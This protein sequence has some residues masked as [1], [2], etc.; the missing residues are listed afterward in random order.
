MAS[1]ISSSTMRQPTSTSTT[2]SHPTKDNNTAGNV[3]KRY[4]HSFPFFFSFSPFLSSPG[5]DNSYDIR[6]QSE[7]LTLMTSPP[8]SCTAFPHNGNLH[9]WRATILGPSDTPYQALTFKLSF[10]FPDRYPFVPPEV[11]F[12]TPIYHPNVDMKGRICLDILKDKWSAVLNVGSVLISLQSLLGEPNKYVHT[13]P[14]FFRLFRYVLG[15]TNDGG[16]QCKS[17]EWS[18][19]GIMGYGHGRI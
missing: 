7:L 6:L 12:L 17:V 19:C 9:H 1:S 3:T 4:I 13:K 14:P 15:G 2:T 11:K 16:V 5:P 10:D 8:P 18:S